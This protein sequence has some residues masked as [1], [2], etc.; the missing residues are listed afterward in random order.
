MDQPIINEVTMT[1]IDPLLEHTVRSNMR[2]IR[3]TTIPVDERKP[4]SI[5]GMAEKIGTSPVYLSRFETGRKGLNC[6]AKFYHD[7]VVKYA[8]ALDVPIDLFY[9]SE[10]KVKPSRQE[11]DLLDIGNRRYTALAD[12]LV[13]TEA[14]LRKTRNIV[15]VQTLLLKEQY[16]V[17]KRV[18]A[19]IKITNER[20]DH[21]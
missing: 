9:Q 5:R 17:I 7:I 21:D 13:E 16:R 19:G 10:P 1:E 18:E 15:R 12:K 14:A 2:R 20:K 4:L 11:V 8:N 3:E 6:K